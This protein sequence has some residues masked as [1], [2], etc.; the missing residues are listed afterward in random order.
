MAINSITVPVSPEATILGMEGKKDGS[1][2][3]V[4]VG[5][6]RTEE[7]RT[8]AKGRPLFRHPVTVKVSD[9]TATEAALTLPSSAPL[10]VY[11]VIELLPGAEQTIRAQASGGDFAELVISISGELK[12]AASKGGQ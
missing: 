2:V 12:P 1:P 8:D 7:Q 4:Y 5:G 10:G 9:D 11:E 6:K 3:Y